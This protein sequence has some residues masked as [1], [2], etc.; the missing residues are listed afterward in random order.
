MLYAVYAALVDVGHNCVFDL[1]TITCPRCTM[2]P[3][4]VMVVTSATMDQQ[5]QEVCWVEIWNGTLATCE[6]EVIG[7]YLALEKRSM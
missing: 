6:E 1:L 3:R 2:L 4:T 5:S 7:R